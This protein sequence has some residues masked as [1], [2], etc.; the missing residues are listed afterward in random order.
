VV[1]VLV[2]AAEPVARAPGAVAPEMMTSRDRRRFRQ[3]KPSL[4]G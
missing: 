2:A 1:A 3:R 4:H